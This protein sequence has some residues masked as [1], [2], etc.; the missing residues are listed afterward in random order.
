MSAKAISFAVV[1]RSLAAGAMVTG[2]VAVALPAAATPIEGKHAEVQAL[3]NSISNAV[4]QAQDNAKAQGLS[5]DA[6]LVAEEAAIQ[7]VIA[8]SGATPDV[9][10][11]ALR[12]ARHNL[13]TTLALTDYSIAALGFISGLVET[14]AADYGANGYAGATGGNAPGPLGAPPSAGAAGGGSAYRNN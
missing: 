5:Y 8:L 7:Q 13:H 12:D 10:L 2:A 1:L 6:A 4:A 9:V 14:A 3:A 11:A